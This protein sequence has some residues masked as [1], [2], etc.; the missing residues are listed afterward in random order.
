MYK[1]TQE[2]EDAKATIVAQ[3]QR[4]QKLQID[5]APGKKSSSWEKASRERR[6]STESDVKS[7]RSPSKRLKPSEA[8]SSGG[9]PP[10]FGGRW[11]AYRADVRK[12]R[13]S[14]SRN[15]FSIVASPNSWGTAC[16]LSIIM[17]I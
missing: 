14:S 16:Y 13:C 2:L 15:F 10:Y 6:S 4:I 11:T 7:L 17:L 3:E 9:P 12:V 8:N 1:A 5:L